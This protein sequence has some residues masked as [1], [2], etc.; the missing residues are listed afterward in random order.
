MR[1]VNSAATAAF[2]TASLLSMGALHAQQSLQAPTPPAADGQAVKSK[3]KM[4]FTPCETKVS[5][6]VDV[7]LTSTVIKTQSSGSVARQLTLTADGQQSHKYTQWSNR[8]G[9]P[10]KIQVDG[11][12]EGGE[13]LNLIMFY[14]RAPILKGGSIRPGE[15]WQSIVANPLDAKVKMKVTT[16]FLG[17]QTQDKV[18]LL[19]FRQIAEH[20]AVDSTH[21]MQDS[22]EFWVNAKTGAVIHSKKTISQY[23][24]K[25][26]GDVFSLDERVEPPAGK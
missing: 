13:G 24:G 7:Q 15:T 22:S 18:R 2:F 12:D 9:R 5:T 8:D 4:V 17:P 16:T 19:K 1:I 10:L 25:K 6:T 14:L 26:A 21:A 23:V 3:V 20:I 11:P